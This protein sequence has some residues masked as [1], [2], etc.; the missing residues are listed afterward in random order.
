M[1]TIKDLGFKD[2]SKEEYK[3]DLDLSLTNLTSLEYVPKILKGMLDCS[4]NK[5]T[6]LKG[7]PKIIKGDFSCFNNILISL[8]YS[9]EK[10][11]GNF[12]CSN[13][14]LFSLEKCTKNITGYFNCT[15][16]KELMNQKSQI[17][18]N[19]IKA[20][21]YITDEG[22]FNFKDIEKEF[23]E[24]AKYLLKNEEI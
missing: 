24:Y 23:E 6:S 9:P 2:L 12:D 11:I 14:N 3:G 8:E 20:N 16:N 10:I 4:Y 1:K 21:H 7:S 19:Q 22:Q 18:K 5:L 13:N 17:I 15:N